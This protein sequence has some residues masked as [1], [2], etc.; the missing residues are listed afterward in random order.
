MWVPKCPQ[1]CSSPSGYHRWLQLPNNQ[2]PPALPSLLE[3][4]FF[5]PRLPAV[6]LWH[7]LWT[8]QATSA[9]QSPLC[10]DVPDP[11]LGCSSAL[12]AQETCTL[13]KTP[14]HNSAVRSGPTTSLTQASLLRHAWKPIICQQQMPYHG[15][16]SACSRKITASPLWWFE[17]FRGC[18]PSGGYRI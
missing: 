16:P 6:G 4:L 14:F 10:T 1:G 8:S 5:N 13:W 7:V 18:S 9:C 11:R 3:E 12:M 2:P 17:S 15:V